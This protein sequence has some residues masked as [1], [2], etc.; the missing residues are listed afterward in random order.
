MKVLIA[1]QS[2]VTRRWLDAE[3]T[4]RGDQV[5]LAGDGCVAWQSIQESQAPQLVLLDADLP[6]TDALDLCRKLR[7]LPHAVP[8]Y[9]LLL[10]RRNQREHVLRGLH[11]GC[12]DF[13]TRPVDPFEFQARLAV[14]R[15]VI[16]LQHDLAQHLGADGLLSMC[17]WCRRVRNADASWS[18][19]EAYL[20]RHASVRVSHGICPDCCGALTREVDA[21]L[22]Q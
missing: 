13:L 3:L 19:F 18:P 8:P 1:E 22:P 6:G 7:E 12:D 16:D 15:R 14:A 21:A 10:V 17:A 9:I 20:S 4:R 2:P 11:A 5:V